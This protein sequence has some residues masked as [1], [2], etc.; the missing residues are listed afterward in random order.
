MLKRILVVLVVLLVVVLL[1]LAVL[2]EMF[3]YL[4][5]FLT[6]VLVVVLAVIAGKAAQKAAQKRGVK[7]S[8]KS[9][10]LIA[11]PVGVI[12]F[13]VFSA[14]ADVARNL[15]DDEE[16][17]FEAS[18]TEKPSAPEQDPLS[19]AP[20]EPKA[21]SEEERVQRTRNARLRPNPAYDEDLCLRDMGDLKPWSAHCQKWRG[22]GRNPRFDKAS[23][24]ARVKEA[25][26]P[27]DIPECR[28]R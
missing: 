27:R 28:R 23:C 24:M 11:I 22:S 12:C 1:G 15:T 18:T 10:Y 26:H 19:P 25:W 2:G 3:N 13:L 14:V 16:V 8:W 6:T 7:T 5:G 4:G 20:V 21:V 9:T 17:S